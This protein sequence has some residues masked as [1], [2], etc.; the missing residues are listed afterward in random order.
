MPEPRESIDYLW[1]DY[2]WADAYTESLYEAEHQNGKLPCHVDLPYI[3]QLQEDYR[4][5]SNEEVISSIVYAPSVDMMRCLSLY[6]AERGIIRKNNSNEIVAINRMIRG[7]SFHGLLIKRKYLNEYLN[8]SGKCLFYCLL[9]EKNIIGTGYQMLDRH[10]LTGAAKYNL[11]GDAE[12]IQPFRNEP[13]IN[14]Q[15]KSNNN[16]DFENSI[17]EWLS[18]FE[19]QKSSFIEHL[20]ELSNDANKIDK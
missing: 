9:G 3:A 12:M 20:K 7:E 2:P 13:E 11:I 6:T 15:D 10:D 14:P 5:I 4:G 17:K 19:E 18:M 1:S 16:D 8:S